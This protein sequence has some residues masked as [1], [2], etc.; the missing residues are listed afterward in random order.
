MAELLK[1]G[2]GRVGKNIFGKSGG[3]KTEISFFFRTFVRVICMFNINVA[4]KSL[5]IPA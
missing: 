1:K 4:G 5:R 3:E 2:E